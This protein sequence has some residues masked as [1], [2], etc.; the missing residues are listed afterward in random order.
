[1]PRILVL[2]DESLIAIMLE[3]WLSELGCETVGPADSVRNAL[4]MVDGT[5]IDGAIL[6]VSIGDE[7]C[8][9]VADALR[10]KGV[11]FAF[12]TGHDAGAV[13]SRFQDELLLQKPFAFQAVSST[14]SKLLD[15]R[16]QS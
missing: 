3:D 2:E 14:V 4:E 6:D 8:F 12:A 11:P 10:E 1:M 16:N 13:A 5:E 9:S 7:N 15:R